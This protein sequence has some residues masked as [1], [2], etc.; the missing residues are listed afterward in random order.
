MKNSWLEGREYTRQLSHSTNALHLS[1][2]SI[3][4][5]T[6]F[7]NATLFTLNNIF[8]TYL[9]L[10]ISLLNEKFLS[11]ICDWYANQNFV[12]AT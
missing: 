12:K 10:L 7:I 5:V 3:L 6:T 2:S 4:S 9:I 11:S 8:Y 1:S